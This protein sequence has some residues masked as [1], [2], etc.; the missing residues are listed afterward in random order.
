MRASVQPDEGPFA[1][2][3][4]SVED[5][6]YERI[7]RSR[8]P[9]DGFLLSLV[10]TASFLEITSDLYTAT[11]ADFFADDADM[12]GWISDSWQREELRHGHALK[13]YV[14]AAWPDFDWRG[15]YSA[16]HTEFAPFSSI[17]QLAPTRALEMAARCVIETGTATFYRMLAQA[18]PEP[19]LSAIAAA[20]SQDEVNHY[21]YFYRAFLRYRAER[22]PG[23]VATARTLWS[24]LR[25]INAE[26]LFYAYKH[27]H[28]TQH[29]MSSFDMRDYRA[30]R[31]QARHFAH[32]HFPHRMASEMLLKPL[33]LNP[34]IGQFLIPTASW[35]WKT[36]KGF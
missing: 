1:H 33:G 15:A 20:I 18:S 2:R 12:V 30:F 3:A 25:E 10:A 9:E 22:N 8:L 32:H 23:R 31:A 26:D 11:L 7:D 13:R 16:F 21:K 27:V 6:P 4:W 19:L 5:I 14:E 17:D 24:R 29:R 34:R 36:S 35:A 28:L